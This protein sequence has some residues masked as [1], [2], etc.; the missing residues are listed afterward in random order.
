MGDDLV[1]Q[2]KKIIIANYDSYAC[3]YTEERSEGNYT[4][5]FSDGVNNGSS[6]LAYEIG[7]LIGLDLEKPKE[8]KYS[9]ED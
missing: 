9:W 3:G 2:L 6:C 8:P 4:D 7:C 1:Q 5:V